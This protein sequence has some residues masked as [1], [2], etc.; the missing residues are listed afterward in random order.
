MSQQVGRTKLLFCFL[1]EV[2]FT[3]NLSV[4][5]LKTICECGGNMGN[6]K[7]FIALDILLRKACFQKCPQFVCVVFG[8]VWWVFTFSK[9]TF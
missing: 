7:V 4:M 2:K 3:E 8:L 1:I 6:K 9:L 5:P